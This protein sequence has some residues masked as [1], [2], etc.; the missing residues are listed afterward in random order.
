MRCL[1]AYL[2]L[3]FAYL[4]GPFAVGCWWVQYILKA[5]H[6]SHNLGPEDEV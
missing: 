2:L 5:S 3:P 4:I 1:L 6:M